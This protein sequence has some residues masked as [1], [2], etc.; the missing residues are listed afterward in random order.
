MYLCSRYPARRGTCPEFRLV[1]LSRTYHVN[2]VSK[3]GFHLSVFCHRMSTCRGDSAADEL[4]AEFHTTSGK[5]LPC[6]TFHVC[7]SPHKFLSFNAA[8]LGTRQILGA[9]SS[10]RIGQSAP[11][12]RRHAGH[13][14]PARSILNYSGCDLQHKAKRHSVPFVTFFGKHLRYRLFAIVGGSYEPKQCR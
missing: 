13:L 10:L 7:D 12:L 11:A 9:P 4:G 2:D 14:N 6:L 5:M 8:A 3:S 1:V